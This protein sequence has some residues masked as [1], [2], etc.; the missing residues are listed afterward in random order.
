MADRREWGSA[1]STRAGI[2]IHDTTDRNRG[3]YLVS[4]IP[5][6]TAYTA[7]ETSV[8]YVDDVDVIPQV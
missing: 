5:E 2:H 7:S 8:S 3:N 6:S 1:C 4:G